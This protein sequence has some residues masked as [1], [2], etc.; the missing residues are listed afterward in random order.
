LVSDSNHARVSRRLFFAF[1]VPELWHVQNE[2][3]LKETYNH[4]L[5]AGLRFRRVP[6]ASLHATVSFLGNVEESK[7]RLLL[8]LGQQAARSWKPFEA[9]FSR[10]RWLPSE[11]RAHVLAAIFKNKEVS[12]MTFAFRQQVQGGGVQNELLLHITLCRLSGKQPLPV[13][14]A[15]SACGSLSISSFSL[16]ESILQPSG[17]SYIRLETWTLG[18]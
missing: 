13:L 1:D 10:Y 5:N 17:S 18:N 6:T 4:L 9:D 14:N 3:I 15:L 8:Q 2:Q 16:Y 7:L 11:T 12:E